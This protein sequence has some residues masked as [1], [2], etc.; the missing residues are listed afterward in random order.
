MTT[1]GPGGK[2]DTETMVAALAA[3]QRLIYHLHGSVRGRMV[4]VL[5]VLTVNLQ[6]LWRWNRSLASA[7]ITDQTDEDAS[8]FREEKRQFG[9]STAT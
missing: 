1:V 6:R 5:F 3:L 8:I 7:L 2:V 4:N 9:Y